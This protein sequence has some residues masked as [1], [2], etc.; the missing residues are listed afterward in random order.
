MLVQHSV[1]ARPITPDTQVLRATDGVSMS[2]L[3]GIVE[4]MSVPRHYELQPENNRRTADWIVSQLRSYGYET[5]L[6][7]EYANV[8]ARSRRAPDTAC[9]L[10]GAHYDSVPGTPAKLT[11]LR[12]MM[13]WTEA[14]IAAV[15]PLGSVGYRPNLVMTNKEVSFRDGNDNGLRVVLR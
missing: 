12:G 8:V 6:Q 3:R 9:V 4:T 15:A 14:N 7:G 2:F 1:N 11:C 5:E 10:V 13:C